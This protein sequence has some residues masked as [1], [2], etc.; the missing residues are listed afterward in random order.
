MMNPMNMN[1]YQPDNFSQFKNPYA[2]P[3]IQ[4][5]PMNIQNMQMFNVYMNKSNN[6]S[7]RNN[8]IHNTNSINQKGRGNHNNQINQ[9]NSFMK[10]PQ[11]YE[12]QT[13]DEIYG[14]IPEVCKYH[15]G[16]KIFQKIYEEGTDEQK[17]KIMNK[18]I[19][20]VYSLS[21]DVFGNYVVQHLLEIVSEQKKKLMINQLY[22]KIKCIPCDSTF[23]VQF[24]ES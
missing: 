11:M 5:Y 7:N 20:E 4:G 19:P 23:K 12:I 15:Y 22:N 17:E 1:P 9:P 6:Q 10:R 3:Q 13:F 18:I 24:I 16:S 21:K 14:S 2:L 8:Y